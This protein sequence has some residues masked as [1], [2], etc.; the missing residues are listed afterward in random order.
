VGRSIGLDVHRDFCQV[1]I[2]DG[3]RARSAGRIATTPEQLRLFAQSL[4]PSDRVVLEAPGNA[5]AIARILEP[6]VAEVVLANAKQVRAI[7]HARIKTD[8][9]DAKVLADLLAADLIPAVWIGDERVRMLRRLVSRRR[10]LVK[11]RTQIKNEIAAALHRN[12]K[13]RNPASDPFSTKGRQWIAA[14]RLPV[15]ERL[16]VD[17]CLR[18]LDFLGAE[19]AEIDRLIAQQVLA[20]ADV[21]RLMTIPG[22]D[23][24]TAATLVAAI[25]DICRFPTSRHL[26]GY[27]GLHP[28][29]RQSGNASA[30][31]GRLS[32][33]GSAAA[34][35]VLVEAAWSAAKSPGP[36]RAFAQRT[37]AR[38]GRHV[39]TVA[40]ARKLAV[41]TWHL[42]T[43]GEDYAFARPSL[44]RRKLRTLELKAGAPRAKP[45][46]KPDP[47][48]NTSSDAAEKRLAEQAELAYR[49]SVADWQASR[50]KAGAGATPE[51][52]SQRPSKGKAARQASCS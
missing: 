17:G 5:L 20:D 32:K 19:L 42:L 9:V 36:L 11:R 15:D 39:A 6:H 31:H 26:V 50:P 24:V 28:R 2:A 18:Q 13:G 37:A 51:R 40:V 12:L 34:R 49:R 30:R 52:A 10:G 29:I 7:S 25:G 16:T 3:G 45:G 14:Q 46:P 23:I 44:V 4:A 33:E 35:H 43:R 38:R 1:A 27:L 8:K 21:R 22:I 41:L 47:V 48:W